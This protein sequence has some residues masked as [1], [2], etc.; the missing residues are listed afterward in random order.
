VRELK[1]HLVGIKANVWGL[2]KT[3]LKTL[4]ILKSLATTTEL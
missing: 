4:K 1:S 2:E 3:A